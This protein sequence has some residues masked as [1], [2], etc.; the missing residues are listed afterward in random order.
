MCTMGHDYCWVLSDRNHCQ[1]AFDSFHLPCF[2]SCRFLIHVLSTIL[3]IPVM[4]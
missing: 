1:F 3:R 4:T 2:Q